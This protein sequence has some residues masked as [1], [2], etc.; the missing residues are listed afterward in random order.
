[1]LAVA[2]QEVVAVQFPRLGREVAVL[3]HPAIALEVT[4]RPT[5]VAVVGVAVM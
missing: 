4:V 3:E 2:Q 5:R 1:M